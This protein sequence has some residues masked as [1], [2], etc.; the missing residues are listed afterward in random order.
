MD[1]KKMLAIIEN[2]VRMD[3]TKTFEQER[4][5]NELWEEIYLECMKTLHHIEKKRTFYQDWSEEDFEQEVMIKVFN[6]LGL[7][8]SQR[9]KFS[10]WLSVVATNTYFDHYKKCENKCND[11]KIGIRYEVVSMFEERDNQ[12]KTNSIDEY[13]YVAG[14]DEEYDNKEVNEKLYAAIDQLR[15]NYRAVIILCDLNGLKTKQVAKI[16]SVRSKD[17]S[18][19]RYRAL[20]QLRHKLHDELEEELCEEFEIS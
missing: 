10:T 13:R 1:N 9:G 7:Y 16:L 11:K 15:E 17:V 20:E 8:V 12:E 19:W 5:F 2:V 14:V 4:C 6:N 18:Q 3:G